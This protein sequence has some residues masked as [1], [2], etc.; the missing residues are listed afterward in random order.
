MCQVWLL[1]SWRCRR[2]L[3]SKKQTHRTQI[4]NVIG[5]DFCFNR[6]TFFL[7]LQPEFIVINDLGHH[8]KFSFGTCSVAAFRFHFIHISTKKMHSRYRWQWTAFRWLDLSLSASI[9]HYISHLH[10]LLAPFS[11]CLPV[12]SLT[13]TVSG[14]PSVTKWANDFETMLGQHFG[15]PLSH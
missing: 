7:G 13:I 6:K 5:A 8:L 4:S 14:L 11:L 12:S 15:I 10:L 2:S 9:K 3:Q 1:N